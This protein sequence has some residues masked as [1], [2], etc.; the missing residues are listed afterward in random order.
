M[1]R[2]QYESELMLIFTFGIVSLKTTP[3]M[4]I[5][6]EKFGIDKEQYKEL[7]KLSINE[8]SARYSLIDKTKEG[9]D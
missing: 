8:L 3:Y 2:K 9:G 6:K 4:K 1:E 5:Y 7:K